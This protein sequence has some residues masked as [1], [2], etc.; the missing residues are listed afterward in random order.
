[1]FAQH[2]DILKPTVV[3][4]HIGEA[5]RLLIAQHPDIVHTRF[6]LAE[7]LAQRTGA[8]AVLKGP[9]SIIQGEQRRNINRSGC[10]AMASAGMGDVLSG[11]IAALL[12]QQVPTFA[13]VCLAVYIHGLAAEEAAKD[14]SLGL[15]AS[16]LFGHIRRI[17]G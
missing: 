13:A 17:L 6:E 15:V 11:I 16:D 3:T 1:L 4:P 14:G 5:K 8:I 12:A 10:P 9:G 2:P 7:H